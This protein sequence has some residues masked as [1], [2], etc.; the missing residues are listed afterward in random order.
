[1]SFFTN[2]KVQLKKDNEIEELKVVNNELN[3]SITSLSHIVDNIKNYLYA[4]NYYDRFNGIDVKEAFNSENMSNNS[5]L[6]SSNEYRKILPVLNSVER[7]VN[8]ID[9][10]V[11][12]R[13]NGINELLHEP[14]LDKKASS[15]YEVNYRDVIDA[16]SSEHLILKNSILTNKGNYSKLKEKINYLNFLESFLNLIPISKPMDDYYISSR[17]GMRI[18]PF[19]KK[20]RMH[21][22]ID[23]VGPLN[24]PVLASADGVVKLVGVRGGFGN[25]IEISHSNNITTVYG[26]LKESL[27]K[28]GDVVKRGDKVGIQGSSG[29]STGHHLHWEVKVNNKNVDPSKFIGIGEKIY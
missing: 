17:F 1:V 20:G 21:N 27:V 24:S 23:F 29:R 26:H 4:L 3:D 22:G 13:I 10:L 14:L 19:T 5:T 25:A 7:D 9:M 16:E 2:V 6:L 12:S 18:D 15:I 11:S 8:N 28:V